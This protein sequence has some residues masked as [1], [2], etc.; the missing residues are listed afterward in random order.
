M[1]RITWL[2]RMGAPGM[3]TVAERVPRW[4]TDDDGT[5]RVEEDSV[6]SI[7]FSDKTSKLAVGGACCCGAPQTEATPE[8]SLSS[9]WYV[10]VSM[11]DPRMNHAVLVQMRINPIARMR[12]NIVTVKYFII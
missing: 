5:R 1:G 2:S 12:L 7:F 4:H 3:D 11:V 9:E 6:P 8:R 10:R